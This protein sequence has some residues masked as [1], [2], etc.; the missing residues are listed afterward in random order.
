MTKTI[1]AVDDTPDNLTFLIDILNDKYKLKVAPSGEKA[2]SYLER[3]KLPDLILLDVFMPGLSG[4]DLLERLKGS[5]K[6]KNIPV[7]LLSAS[8]DKDDEQRAFKTGACGY[9]TKPIN[10]TLLFEEIKKA[11]G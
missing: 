10:T 11:L 7:I 8:F 6:T 9:I 1:L 3:S 5:E 4:F 2:L